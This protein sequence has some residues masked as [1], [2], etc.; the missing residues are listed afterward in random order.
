MQSGGIV[1]P[2]NGDLV[3]YHQPETAAVSTAG[4]YVVASYPQPIGG[5][6]YD[7]YDAA[8][9]AARARAGNGAVNVF[10]CE[11]PGQTELITQF[12]AL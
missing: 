12:R 6:V 5:D 8:I 7:S 2:I 9:A 10:Y 3:V 4:R 11:L 1:T